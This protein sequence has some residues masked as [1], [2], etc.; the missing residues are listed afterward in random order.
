MNTIIDF[1]PEAVVVDAGE[2]PS[3]ET[4]L[5]MLRR[6][7]RIV[8]CDGAA[9]RYLLSGRRP[10]RIV[11]DCDSISSE[12]R[13]LHA[14]ILRKFPDQDTNDQTKSVRYLYSKGIRKIAILGA[15]GKREDHTLGNISLLIEYLRRGI[16]ARAYTDYGVFIAVN[17]D[18][19][20]H[21]PPGTQIS[22][23]NFG[24]SCMSSEGLR[25]PLRDFRNW[26]E[27]TLNETIADSFTIRA[28]GDYLV[29]LNYS[30]END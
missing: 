9:D 23:F 28:D 19:E 26:W 24:A 11:G 15:T 17:G 8:C 12:N 3:Q 13:R 20:F 6:T 22:V 27:G 25:W 1:W 30:A 2:F 4:A 7:D 14:D 29:F 21:C 16:D 18:R 10:W 5:E